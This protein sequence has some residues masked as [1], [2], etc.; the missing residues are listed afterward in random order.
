MVYLRGQDT[1]TDGN[2]LGRALWGAEARCVL[3][4]CTC[5]SPSGG[6]LTLRASH[7]GAAGPAVLYLNDAVD[8]SENL[9]PW[10]WLVHVRPEG[11][12]ATR[13]FV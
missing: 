11:R 9:L 7:G 12:D 6:E 5:E 4:V 3:T 13:E 1:V 8:L 2:G 10:L